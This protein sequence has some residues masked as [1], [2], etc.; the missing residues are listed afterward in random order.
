V[1]AALDYL[2]H[3][4]R[5]S[6]RFGQVLRET[7]PDAHVPSCP[8]W[9]ADDLLWHLGEVQWFWGTIVREHLPDGEQ[10]ETLKPDRPGDR[11]GL[12]TF[13]QDASRD[14]R[15]IL[16][17]QA[18]DT[19]A[20]TWSNDHTVGFIRRRQAHEALIHRIDAELTAGTVSPM[21][22]RLSADGVDEVL[23]VMYGG[24][25]AWGRFTPEG[26]ETVRVLTS[27]TGDSWLVTM[28][29]FSGTDPDSGTTYDEAGVHVGDTDH[30]GDVAATLTG[31]AADLDSWL[32]R[33][34]TVV[35]LD[36]SG[37]QGL[38]DRFESA[39]AAGID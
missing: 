20:W 25:P 28:G 38:L 39:I 35:P 21:D 37:D 6:D 30:G 26:S 13:Y 22:A 7:S 10:A 31:S 27:D 16:A 9:N 36:R 5:N 34:P 18:P 17:A 19:P 8:E 3:L 14:L 4:T 29:K 12:L 15:E 1:S 24:M 32:W 33:R 2:D 11:A 23:R